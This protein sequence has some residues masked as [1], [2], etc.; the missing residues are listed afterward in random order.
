MLTSIEAFECDKCSYKW[1]SHKYTHKNPP[2]ACAKC[3]SPYW[4]R[5]NHRFTM[6]EGK[7]LPTE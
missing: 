2:V 4:N 7:V 6:A 5:G 3:K 1:I